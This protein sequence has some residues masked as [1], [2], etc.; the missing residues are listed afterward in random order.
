MNIST[1]QNL[2][3]MQSLQRQYAENA[4]LPNIDWQ[5]LFEQQSLT[6]AQITALDTIYQSA[7]PLALTVFKRLNFD[8][9]SPTAYHPQGL[10]LFDQLAKQEDRFL[11]ILTAMS[12][13]LNHETRHQIWSML[14]RGGAVLVFKTWLGLVKTGRL[15]IDLSQFD[16]LSDLLWIKT[17]PEQ[18]AKQLRVDGE[19]EYEHLFLTF[20]DQ[21]F[22]ERFNCLET[23]VLFSQLGVYDPVFLSLRDETV[24]E[25]FL[26]QQLVTEEQIE[27]LQC[28]LNPLNCADQTSKQ[29]YLV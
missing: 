18:L 1:H 9:F 13:D 2:H 10:G 8:V 11:D 17:K 28:A 6:P 24:A 5:A 20:E 21:V 16:E 25:F 19:A 22:L 15:C 14:L 3:A 7:I 23:A 12:D 26:A 27:E 4:L 29:D